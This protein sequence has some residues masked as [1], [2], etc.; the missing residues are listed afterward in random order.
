MISIKSRIMFS[1]QVCEETIR[2]IKVYLTLLRQNSNAE[3]VLLH[4]RDVALLRKVRGA[5]KRDVGCSIF[6]AQ[7]GG[8]TSVCIQLPEERPPVGVDVSQRS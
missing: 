5:A 1:R 8:S 2:N 3:S 4:Y 6:S 7:S